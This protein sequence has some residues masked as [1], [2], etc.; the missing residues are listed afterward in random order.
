MLEKKRALPYQNTQRRKAMNS[1]LHIA[2]TCL[3]I[4]ALLMFLALFI[5]YLQYQKKRLSVTLDAD[6]SIPCDHQTGSGIPLRIPTKR[7]G[8]TIEIFYPCSKCKE[9]IP[10]SDNIKQ[11][12]S[13]AIQDVKNTLQAAGFKTGLF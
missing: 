7:G 11:A 8:H 1:T 10:F 9:V 3:A 12:T 13:R 4:I 5:S 2:I 6:L